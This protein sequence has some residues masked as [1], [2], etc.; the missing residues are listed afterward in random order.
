MLEITCPRCAKT[1]PYLAEFKGREILCL[2]C[3]SHFVIPDLGPHSAA[4]LPPLVVFKA[5]EPPLPDTNRPDDKP[6]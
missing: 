2:G 5:K 6:E 3:G 4:G 1:I